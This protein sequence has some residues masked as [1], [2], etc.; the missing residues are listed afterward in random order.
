MPHLDPSPARRATPV[1]PATSRDLSIDLLR[2][3]CIA[4][5]NLNECPGTTRSSWSAVVIIVAGYF[6]PALRLCSGE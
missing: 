4:A 2:A 3:A 1:P 6:A 5:A